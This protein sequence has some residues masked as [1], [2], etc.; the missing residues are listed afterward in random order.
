MY[1]AVTPPP[2]PNCLIINELRDFQ[3][4]S[5]NNTLLALTKAAVYYI[6]FLTVFTRL[7]RE[8]F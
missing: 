1:Q 8:Y 4:I 3:L 5:L 7:K 6:L 2:P